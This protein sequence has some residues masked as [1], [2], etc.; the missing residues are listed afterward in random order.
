M[1]TSHYQNSHGHGYGHSSLEK[2]NYNQIS[3]TVYKNNVNNNKHTYQNYSFDELW[4][5]IKTNPHSGLCLDKPEK[6]FD[7]S[8]I[9]P[10]DN[11]FELHS[12]D[13]SPIPNYVVAADSLHLSN[14]HVKTLKPSGLLSIFVYIANPFFRDAPM[15]LA[16]NIRLDFGTQFLVNL[17]SILSGTK[18]LRKKKL[19]SETINTLMNIPG[20]LTKDKHTLISLLCQIQN[21]QA[22]LVST[23]NFSTC[24]T[25]QTG[26]TAPTIYFSSDPAEWTSQNQTWIFDI[27]GNWIAEQTT[28]DSGTISLSS[29]IE[30]VE[31]KGWT[32]VWPRLDPDIKKTDMVEFLKDTIFWT[33][34]DEKLKKETLAPKYCRMKVLQGLRNI[35]YGSYDKCKND[36]LE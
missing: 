30:D 14:F 3:N 9:R 19:I 20:I 7:K 10:T 6:I 2:Q 36:N 4:E 26:N 1:A 29:W 32:I 22:I 24:D 35:S 31:N 34:S 11:K 33:T 12:S 8:T 18:Y 13:R 27:D 23:N 21:I 25:N 28:P 17:D 5:F 15:N 16:K